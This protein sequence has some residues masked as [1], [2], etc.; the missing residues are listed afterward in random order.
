M[1]MQIGRKIAHG[2]AA[3]VAGLALAEAVFYI[4]DDGAFPHVAFYRADAALNARLAPHA[5]QRIAFGGNPTTTI[6]TNCL[7]HVPQRPA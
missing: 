4:R 7:E 1:S 3:L 2:I 6:T 5:S